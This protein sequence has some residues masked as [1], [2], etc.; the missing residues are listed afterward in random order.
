MTYHKNE[1]NGY[2]STLLTGHQYLYLHSQ[3][4]PSGS[5]GYPLKAGQTKK[6]TV[7]PP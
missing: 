4:T 6:L 2:D 1:T 3:K 7:Q 5:L